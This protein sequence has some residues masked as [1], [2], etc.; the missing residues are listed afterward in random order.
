MPA[1]LPPVTGATDLL[2]RLYT[3]VALTGSLYLPA[4]CRATCVSG[5]AASTHLPFYAGLEPGYVDMRLPFAGSSW[6]V[7]PGTV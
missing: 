3:G 6:V 7:C 1:A 5:Q 4:T 2:T